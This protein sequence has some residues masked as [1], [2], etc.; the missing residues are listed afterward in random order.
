MNDNKQPDFSESRF[1][2]TLKTYGIIAG[3]E[4]AEK[5]LQRMP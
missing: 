2:D 5:A 4:V 1:W 3:K